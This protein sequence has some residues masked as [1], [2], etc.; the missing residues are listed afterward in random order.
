MA[1]P[2]LRLLDLAGPQDLAGTTRLRAAV[3]PRLYSSHP[4]S[5]CNAPCCRTAT[6]EITTVEALR[7]AFEHLLSLEA[8]VERMDCPPGVD[9][10]RLASVPIP[11]R[12]GLTVL[13][14]RHRPAEDGGGCTFL[15]GAL[16]Q[17]RCGVHALRPGSCRLFPFHIQAGAQSVAVGDPAVCPTAWLRTPQLEKDVARDWAAWRRDVRLEKRLVA[18]WVALG[19]HTAGWKDYAAYAVEFAQKQLKLTRPLWI[20]PGQRFTG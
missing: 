18:G 3:G 14:L 12:D 13:R 5:T 1:S 8:V 9:V 20:A 16:E 2:R 19:G 15:M 6:V 11:L 17:R 10:E 7:L 4:C